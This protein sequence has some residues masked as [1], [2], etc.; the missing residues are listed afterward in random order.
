MGTTFDLGEI[1]RDPDSSGGQDNGSTLVLYEIINVDPNHPLDGQAY[2]FGP[3]EGVVP[4]GGIGGH[5]TPAIDPYDVNALAFGA[6]HV[7]GGNPE[8]AQIGPSATPIPTGEV[9]EQ[10]GDRISIT[11]IYYVPVTHEDFQTGVIG[12]VV[13]EVDAS[14]YNIGWNLCGELAFVFRGEPYFPVDPGTLAYEGDLSGN[15]PI[16]TVSGIKGHVISDEPANGQVLVYNG[17][18][19]HWEPKPYVGDSRIY[20]SIQDPT[21]VFLPTGQYVIAGQDT[22]AWVL[23]TTEANAVAG[24]DLSL[25]EDG[26]NID[27]NTTGTYMVRLAFQISVYFSHGII[28]MGTIGATGADGGGTRPAPGWIA[29]DPDQTT[30]VAIGGNGDYITNWTWRIAAG[31]KLNFAVMALYSDGGLH[32][33]DGLELD[34]VRVA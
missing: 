14:P 8:T 2:Y 28:Y 3:F 31:G 26:I 15:F 17:S 19:Q 33:L 9:V 23:A 10:Y 11:G 27:V 13:G 32:R 16:V 20:L 6:G 4:E 30:T 29:G 25:N 34:I 22:P 24:N 1:M 5:P 21:D 12:H 18:A 7:L